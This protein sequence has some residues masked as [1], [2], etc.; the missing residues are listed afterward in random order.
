[1]SRSHQLEW[2]AKV[3]LTAAAGLLLCAAIAPIIESGPDSQPTESDGEAASALIAYRNETT[4]DSVL[5]GTSLTYRLKEQLFLPMHIKNL[6]IPGRSILTGLE[7]VASYPKL[8]ARIFVEINVMTWS[9]DKD[10]VKKFSYNSRPFFHVA[11][12]IRSTVALIGRPVHKAPLHIDENILDNP[13]VEYD[14]QVYIQRAKIEWSGHNQ[15]ATILSSI[16][17]LSHLVQQIEARGSRVYFFE[18][19]L[20]GVMAETDV[21]KTTNAA[22]H[23]RFK[24]ASRWLALTYPADQLRFRDHAHLDERSAIIVARAMRGAM[25]RTTAG[26]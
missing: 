22:L 14:N 3:A 16:D 10:F 4:P 12:P 18:L 25:M 8:P 19:P 7:I 23:Q 1:M 5:V 20:A 26:D 6:A 13:P 2:L 9:I 15:D 17:S 21:A 24:D 11:P